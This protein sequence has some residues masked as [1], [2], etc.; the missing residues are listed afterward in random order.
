MSLDTL[1]LTAGLPV[2]TASIT[3]L[4]YANASVPEVGCGVLLTI[5]G[6]VVV[7]SV[8]SVSAPL[9]AASEKIS[10]SAKTN[11]RILTTFFM[12]MNLPSNERIRRMLYRE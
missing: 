7:S 10:V 12:D 5:G 9:Q 1:T 8:V 11:D 6:S 2:F 4:K 3:R